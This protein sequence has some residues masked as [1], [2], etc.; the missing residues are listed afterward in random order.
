MI[1]KAQPVKLFTRSLHYIYLKDFLL[2]FN[3]NRAL[4][5]VSLPT[6]IGAEL[7]KI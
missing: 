3:I 5:E 4:K 7:P 2:L 6:S 1:E